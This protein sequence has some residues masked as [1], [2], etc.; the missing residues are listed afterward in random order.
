[1]KVCDSDML[2]WRA[3]SLHLRGKT[4]FLL[5]YITLAKHSFMAFAR[6]L[7]PSARGLRCTKPNRG[8]FGT[9]CHHC[10]GPRD[11]TG[12]FPLTKPWSSVLEA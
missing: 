11:A 1:M 7:S 4:M 12:L 8:N 9:A 3:K 6:P 10:T 5:L 2:F